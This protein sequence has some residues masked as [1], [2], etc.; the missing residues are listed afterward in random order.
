MSLFR[1]FPDKQISCLAFF[2]LAVLRCGSAFIIYRIG[3]FNEGFFERIS[4]NELVAKF[5]M[6]QI[7]SGDGSLS[8]VSRARSL[9]MY[10]YVH[11]YMLHVYLPRYRVSCSSLARRWRDVEITGL[12]EHH[13]AKQIGIYIK[14]R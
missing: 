3:R 2:A 13:Q 7:S 12:N 1:T 6:R 8:L 4:E 5:M 9:C 14:R 11:A 10:I